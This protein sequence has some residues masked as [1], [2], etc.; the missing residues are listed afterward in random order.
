MVAVHLISRMFKD[1]VV[2]EVLQKSFPE[3]LDPTTFDTALS[4]LNS[5]EFK[6]EKG[7]YILNRVDLWL[8]KEIAYEYEELHKLTWISPQIAEI[9]QKWVGARVLFVRSLSL[10]N[11]RAKTLMIC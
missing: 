9:A 5:G 2:Q 1:E 7:L 10:P 8:N 4:V 11:T 6:T 3:E